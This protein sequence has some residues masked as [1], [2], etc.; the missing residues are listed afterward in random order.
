VRLRGIVI[1]R[2]EDGKIIEDWA[3]SDT[4]ELARQLGVWRSLLLVAKHHRL[5]RSGVSAVAH[6]TPAWRSA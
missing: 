5:L 1:S 2:F 6:D 3:S 4:F